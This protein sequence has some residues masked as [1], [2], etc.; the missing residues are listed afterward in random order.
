MEKRTPTI[1]DNTEMSRYELLVDGQTA[2]LEYEQS[3]GCRTLT[4]TFVPSGLEGRGIGRQLVEAALADIRARGLR[5]RPECSFI[6][7]YVQRHPE[8]E[9]WVD[10]ER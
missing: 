9:A 6:V 8:W 4:H 7:R 2:L 5:F 3:A 10:K 1:K